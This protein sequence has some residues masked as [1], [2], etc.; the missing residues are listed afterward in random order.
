MKKINLL[1]VVFLIT[2]TISCAE[3]DDL[4][5]ESIYYDNDTDCPINTAGTCCDVDGRILVIPNNTYKYTYKGVSGGVTSSENITWSVSNSEITIISGQG[6]N[7][8]IF[9][10]SSNFII[11]EISAIGMV[12]RCCDCQSTISISNY[13]L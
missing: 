13:N 9:A 8:A 5:D 1:I 6:T 10:F 7:E 11:G 3:S 12:G 4:F 2:L